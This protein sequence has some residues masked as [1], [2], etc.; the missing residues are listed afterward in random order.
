MYQRSIIS[1]S[2]YKRCFNA[3]G[4]TVAALFRLLLKA[5]FLEHSFWSILFGAFFLE[6][7]FWSILF[8]AFFLEHSYWNI[9]FKA[10]FLVHPEVKQRFCEV[11]EKY[12]VTN[13]RHVQISELFNK[14]GDAFEYFKDNLGMKNMC[15]P[16]FNYMDMFQRSREFVYES[17]TRH[18]YMHQELDIRI[19]IKN[20]TFVNA[21]RTRHSYMHQELDI[22]ICIKN[23]TF[24]YA[25]RTQHS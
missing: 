14:I 13:V 10:F 7:S 12:I 24:V 8:G 5:F 23:S 16:L 2:H 17:R 20:S 11:R 21:S 1:C 6:H 19:C 9:L 4:V 18:S 3:H 22:R 25:S 15:K